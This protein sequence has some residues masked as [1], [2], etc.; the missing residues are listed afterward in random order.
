MFNKRKLSDQEIEDLK[1]N[2]FHLDTFATNIF[3]ALKQL[4]EKKDTV[5]KKETLLWEFCKEEYG[6]L[7]FFV[8]DRLTPTLKKANKFLKK[9]NLDEISY[10]EKDNI[11]QDEEYIELFLLRYYLSLDDL[12]APIEQLKI[13]PIK[14]FE[15]FKTLNYFQIKSIGEKIQLLSYYYVSEDSEKENLNTMF[16]KETKKNTATKIEHIHNDYALDKI[17]GFSFNHSERTDPYN[18]NFDVDDFKEVLNR[19][20]NKENNVVSFKK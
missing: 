3:S 5:S 19:I 1:I 12:K 17:T 16:E 10:E 2:A 15:F 20:K 8:N 9:N 18:F 11:I 6:R 13:V 14:G 7:N 4:K